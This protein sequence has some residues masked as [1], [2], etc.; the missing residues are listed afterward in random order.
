MPLL[1][2]CIL[3]TVAALLYGLLNRPAPATGQRLST[4]VSGRSQSGGMVATADDRPPRSAALLSQL[5]A[6]LPANLRNKLAD[7]LQSAGMTVQPEMFILIWAAAA[8]GLPSLYLFLTVPG[9][10]G[11]STTQLGLLLA[12]TGLCAYV[13]LALVKSRA[14]SRGARLLR[15]LPDTMDLLTTCV[16]AGLAIDAAL[17]KVAEKAK[18]PLGAEVRLV[19]RTMAMGRP[20]REALEQLAARTKVPDLITFVGAVVQAESMGVS[21]GQVLRVQAEAVRVRRKQRAEQAAYKAPVK[22]IIVLAFF[23]FPSMFIVILGP[24]VLQIMKGGLL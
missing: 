24:A 3:L 10:S 16:E 11:F 15:V 12:I 7:L 6:V 14:R 20:R 18:E 19:L 13:P 4:A 5:R 17:Q 23:I 22:I 1:A 8:I 2:L 9:S 21:L